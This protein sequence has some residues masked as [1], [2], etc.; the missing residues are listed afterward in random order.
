MKR[1]F[2]H[3]LYSS[4]VVWFDHELLTVGEAF[5]NQNTRLYKMTDDNLSTSYIFGSPYKQWV[6]DSSVPNA[7]IPSGVT[8]NGTFVPRN[9]SGLKL[10]FQ[11]GRAV[12]ASGNGNALVSG[13]YAVKD[14]NIYTTTKSDVELLFE[15]RYLVNPVMPQV[16][17]GVPDD[18]LIAPCI[19]L[20]IKGFH[21]TQLSFGGQ[22][23]TEIN[24]R[25]VI[26]SDDEF[27]LNGV[28]NIFV[29]TNQRNFLI[30]TG[31][32]LNRYNDIKNGYYSYTGS[33]CSSFT[34]ENL[35]YIEHV[36][37]TKFNQSQVAERFPDLYVGFLDF[38]IQMHRFPRA[39]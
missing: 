13:S 20:K 27:K 23:S 17:T 5:A 37:F 11:N 16:I 28:G 12:F 32:P 14:F 26:L 36:S 38:K 34:S 30:M 2:I 8:Y 7:Q 10:D 25:A 4:F 35:A 1:D 29:D 3:D 24:L 33:V 15:T 9:T 18:K 19:F 31:T 21:N 39:G 22:D 6:Y